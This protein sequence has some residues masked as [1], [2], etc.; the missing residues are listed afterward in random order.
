MYRACI[1]SMVICVTS[2]V[3]NVPPQLTSQW[4]Y[5]YSVFHF[6]VV[7]ELNVVVDLRQEVS[8]RQMVQ[9]LSPRRREHGNVFE[10]VGGC[11]EIAISLVVS[12]KQGPRC[13]M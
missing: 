2:T 12:P 9:E 10:E 1:D 13:S 11:D 5:P 6:P 3:C 4:P 7:C 8:T